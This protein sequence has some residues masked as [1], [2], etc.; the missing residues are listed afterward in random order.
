MG[1]K[2]N[3][4]LELSILQIKCL[5]EFMDCD[6]D[7]PLGK[8]K[9]EAIYNAVQ[10]SEYYRR[11]GFME[12]FVILALSTRM[13]YIRKARTVDEINRIQ[14]CPRPTYN[15]NSIDG[16]EYPNEAEECM[17]WSIMSEKVKLDHLAYDRYV[18]LFEKLTGIKIA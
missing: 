16:G 8:A 15:C 5:S 12:S 2:R 7:S 17:L 6:I 14:K 13:D 10:R 9:V 3:T 1:E 4:Y 11:E 18:Y